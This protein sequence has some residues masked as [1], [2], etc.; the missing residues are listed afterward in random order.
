[1]VGAGVEVGEGISGGAFSTA[2]AA[3]DSITFPLWVFIAWTLEV[4]GVTCKTSVETGPGTGFAVGVGVTS[5]CNGTEVPGLATS[6]MCSSIFEIISL[7]EKSG[8]SK[9]PCPNAAIS[10]ASKNSIMRY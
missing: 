6:A 2:T 7:G 5:D 4:S 9:A 10:T 3:T 1:M 8:R